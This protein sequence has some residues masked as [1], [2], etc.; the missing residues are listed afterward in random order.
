MSKNVKDRF[1]LIGKV[2][3]ITGGA[4]FLGPKHAEAVAEFGAIPIILDINETAIDETVARIK[5]DYEV[6]CLG[7]N[8]DITKRDSLVAVCAELL[9]KYGHIDAL[10]NNAANDPKIK[11]DGPTMTALSRLEN[12][13]LE[14]WEN[15]LAVGLTGAFLCSQI[16]GTVMKKQKKGVILNI[17]SDLGLIA[18]DQ[19]IYRQPGLEDDAQPVKPVTYSVLKHGLIGLTKYLATYWAGDGIRVNA[20]S[21]SGVYNQQ[22]EEFVKKLTNLVPLGRMSNHDEYKAA[23]V[24]LISEASSYMT[25]SNLVID[26]GKTCW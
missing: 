16:F 3:I 1:D 21:P 2:V 14:V 24:F 15:D 25:G 6:D 26:G 17:A 5:K 20:L 8:V 7:F 13:P 23:V 22:P 12:F 10:I 11:S 4:G 18:P 9:D 19:R